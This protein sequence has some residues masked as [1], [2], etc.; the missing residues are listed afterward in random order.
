[1]PRTY[2]EGIL[3]VISGPSGSGKTTLWKKLVKNFKNLVRSISVTTRPKR[4]KEKNGKDYWFVSEEEFMKMVRNGEFL[5]WAPVHGYYYGTPRKNIEEAKRKG[6]DI[7]LEIDV[8]GAMKVKKSSLKPVLI[9]VSPP[10]IDELKNR[11][12][13]RGDISEE[14]IRRRMEIARKEMEYIPEY[15]YLIVNNDL[16]SAYKNLKA[17]IIAE[18]L[19]TSRLK[20]EINNK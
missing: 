20:T 4:G 7:I 2:S 17:V 1:M 13:K 14:E 19:R 3:F 15:D 11:L 8:Q 16:K 10:S 9:F 18:K 12:R 5:E 6:L